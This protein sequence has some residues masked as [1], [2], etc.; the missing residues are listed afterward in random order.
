MPTFK[1]FDLSSGSAHKEEFRFLHYCLLWKKWFSLFS[2]TEPEKDV[3]RS[4]HRQKEYGLSRWPPIPFPLCYDKEAAGSFPASPEYSDP[5]SGRWFFHWKDLSGEGS[6]FC[7]FGEEVSLPEHPRKMPHEQIRCGHAERFLLLLFFPAE[8]GTSA[9]SATAMKISFA[10]FR[11]NSPVS[12]TT[13]FSFRERAF[14]AM[15]F[16]CFSFC[17]NSSEFLPETRAGCEIF[18]SCDAIRIF[19]FG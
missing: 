12:L 15:Y 8:A 9:R 7:R 6:W 18:S 17:R 1:I 13:V 5:R 3:S 2:E 14:P 16:F 11:N 19:S 4:D 10:A